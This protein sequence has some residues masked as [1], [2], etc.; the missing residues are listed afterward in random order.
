MPL[1]GIRDPAIT[2][3]DRVVK[4]LFDLVI[5]GIGVVLLGPA[6]IVVGVAISWIIPAPLLSDC[7]G[8]REW[9]SISHVEIQ[10]DAGR[11]RKPAASQDT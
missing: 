8:W 5:A 9:S 10:D 2:G 11:F 4:R 3:M 7:Q 1:I 6:I